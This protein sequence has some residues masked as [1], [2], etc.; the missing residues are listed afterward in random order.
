AE[1]IF[2]RDTFLREAVELRRVDDS[3]AGMAERIGA[4]IVSQHEEDVRA[5]G[6]MGRLRLNGLGRY[7]GD[8]GSF[9]KIASRKI[10]AS[11]TSPGQLHCDLHQAR[12]EGARDAAEVCSGTSARIRV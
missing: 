5:F 11:K 3:I 1:M 7:C 12:G 9:Q 2:E 8:G 6:W 10:H 4:L